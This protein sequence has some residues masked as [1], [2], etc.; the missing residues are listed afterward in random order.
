MC[1]LIS[2]LINTL[3]RDGFSF[4]ELLLNNYQSLLQMRYVRIQNVWFLFRDKLLLMITNLRR[5]SYFHC[6]QLAS[7][8]TNLNQLTHWDCK[9][10]SV[11]L[12]KILM[13]KTMQD[14][15]GDT[16]IIFS[17]SSLR[18]PECSDSVFLIFLENKVVCN[19]VWPGI[20]IFCVMISMATASSRY[21]VCGQKQLPDFCFFSFFKLVE[22]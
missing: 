21:S 10:L 13:N 2:L 3:N 15:A 8:N 19:S 1:T 20:S 4:L 5:W 6:I 12:M 17:I 14:Q 16:L 9:G 11:S 7:L 22:F 18:I